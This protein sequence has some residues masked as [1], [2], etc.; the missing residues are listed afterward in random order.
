MSGGDARAELGV[1]PLL[2]VFG[3]LDGTA[4]P[5]V[6]LRKG[7]GGQGGQ[8]ITGGE[9]FGE[10]RAHLWQWFR[11]NSAH[12]RAGVGEEGSGEVLGPM[13]KLLRRFVVVEERR[14]Y[15]GAVALLR[16]RE[17]GGGW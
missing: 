7:Y 15:D 3:V 9:Q 14:V 13:A 10:D 1:R 17:N 2:G 16:H 4:R 6:V 5:K 12:P 8:S 11:R